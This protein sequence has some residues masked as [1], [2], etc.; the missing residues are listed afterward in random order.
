MNTKKITTAAV[1]AALIFVVTWLVRIP[2][3][4]GYAAYFNFGDVVIY[5]CAYI[6]GGPLAMAAAA[7][8]SG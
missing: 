7:A 5:S 3:A 8:G 6:L 2:V 1:M 4:P